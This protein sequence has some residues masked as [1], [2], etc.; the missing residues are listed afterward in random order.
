[1]ITNTIFKS[2]IRK[3]N[4][5]MVVNYSTLHDFICNV[6]LAD[7]YHKCNINKAKGDIFELICKYYYSSLDMAVY[8]YNE[9]P[10]SLKD[11]L[12][13]PSRDKGID[14]IYSGKNDGT[15]VGVQCK[16]RTNIERS[17]DKN[18][19]AGFITEL[20]RSELNSG[21][22]FTNV[23]QITKYFA[24]EDIKWITNARLQKIINSN[25]I[26]Y[27]LDS[28]ALAPIKK[29]GDEK[30]K[31]LRYYQKNAVN[32]LIK[33][34]D[35]DKQ[36]IMFC[37]T[38]KTIVM[39]EYI[40]RKTPDRVVV[41]MPSLHLISQFYKRLMSNFPG[42]NILCI[43]SQMDKESLTCG[44]ETDSEDANYI[45]KEFIA[46]D[47]D[48][49]YTTDPKLIA[50]R[51]KSQKIIVLCT[52]QSSFLLESQEFDLGI[53]DEAHKT[54]NSETFGFCLD[55]D[56]CMIDTRLYFTATPRYYKNIKSEDAKC[57]SMSDSSVY[58]EEI[59]N[60]S[61]LQ[62]RDDGYVL[63]FQIV[64]YVVPPGL[65]DIVNE[66]HIEKDG[67]D[68]PANVLISAIQ[69]AQHI[70]DTKS[71]HKILTY[72]S[73]INN[74]IQYK[75]TLNYVLE[76]YGINATVFHMSGKTHMSQRQEIFNEFETADI[77]IIC[78]SKVLNEGVD[79][80]CV[81]TIMFVDPRKST[82]DVTQCVGRGMRL[83]KDQTVCNIIIPIHYDHIDEEH[84]FSQIINILTAMS[85]I[86]DKLVEYFVTKSAKN[87]VTIKK[88]SFDI[89]DDDTKVLSKYKLNDVIENLNIRVM[90]SRQLGF[91]YKMALLFEFCDANGRVPKANE[92]HKKINIGM[93]LNEQK[94]KIKDS[95]S[96]IYKKL[97]VNEHV[98]LSLDSFLEKN[99]NKLTFDDYV[100]LLFEF[101]DKNTRTPKFSE[102]YRKV[103]I[104]QWLSNQKSRLNDSNSDI[105]KKLA[106]NEHVKLN[107]DLYLENKDKEKLE[108]DD[109]IA[110][111]FEFCNENGRIPK[112]F[113]QYKKVNMGVWL[114]NQK[115]RLNDS[116]SDIYKKLATNEHVK[117]CL[118]EYLKKKMSSGEW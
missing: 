32:A 47:V 3:Y 12:N 104:G 49:K 48:T 74:A 30:I 46:L 7:E 68:V 58:G 60:Y 109:Y 53:F 11:K 26:D 34:K 66:K 25:F 39:I 75:K 65:D 114:T 20:N 85:E 84:D 94:K 31:K 55:D 79:I 14:I 61:Y 67:L 1:M 51:M 45:L 103:N 112:R 105:Y 16:W 96:D 117:L 29:D 90:E 5:E 15:W 57:V 92:Q 73:T 52:Y 76:L 10:L 107:L 50:K 6:N 110:L 97:A 8:M 86:D 111:L 88:M 59:Y 37:G 33:S 113:E 22:M 43:C 38:G 36:C 54:V 56:N 4:E 63:D 106:I 72:H 40:K 89:G 87:K 82:I 118:D 42:Q 9:I 115:S 80:P 102:Q 70:K 24:N 27:I 98:R 19:V 100:A 116:N 77:G 44:E 93:W 13:L 2:L 23:K 71:C 62:A 83:Y 81:D 64:A 28:T 91:S 95:S 35:R 17:I 18:L 41:L 108:F 99:K 21:V 101:C 78:S 69:L